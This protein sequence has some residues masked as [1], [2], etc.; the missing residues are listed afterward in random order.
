MSATAAAG[1]LPRASSPGPEPG[2]VV[3]AA[4]MVAHLTL[5]SIHARGMIG[6]GGV[7]RGVLDLLLPS[8]CAH[9]GADGPPLCAECHGGLDDEPLERVIESG[10][11]VRST[12]RFDPVVADALHA[13]KAEGRTALCRVFAPPLVSALVRAVPDPHGVAVVPVPTSVAA[14]RRRGF[15]VVDRL[16]R[17]GRVPSVSALRAVRRVQDQRTLG[18]YERAEN[19]RGAFRVRSGFLRPGA[20]VVIVDDV[21]TTGA[22]I[23]EAQRA[24]EDAGAV[25]LGAATAVATMRHALG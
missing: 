2:P 17:A 15:R 7:V 23:Q 21:V 5:G 14:M 1:V 25:V 4:H 10:L 20:A 24:L 3:P 6:V 18:R 8:W 19:M 16:L 9:C 22:T 11:R 13:L 12:W